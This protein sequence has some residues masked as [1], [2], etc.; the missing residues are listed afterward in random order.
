MSQPPSYWLRSDEYVYPP[1]QGDASCGVA[2]IGGG[3]AGLSTAL[4]LSRRGAKVIL[5]ERDTIG[6]GSTGRCG[7]LLSQSS[8]F[9]L[10][11]L[12]SRFGNKRGLD[13]YRSILKAIREMAATVRD[14]NIECDLEQTN[15]YFVATEKAHIPA[16]EEELETLKDYGY[17][18]RLVTGDELPV[19]GAF[20]ALCKPGDYAL[21]P[22]RFAKGLGSVIAAHA[23]IHEHTGVARIRNLNGKV[24]LVTD[25]GA[26][27]TSD[28]VVIATN[29]K[30]LNAG[31]NALA[32]P[33]VS[34]IAITEPLPAAATEKLGNAGL[35]D[36]N[37]NYYYVR[38]LPDGGMMIGGN[39]TW[40]ST[41]GLESVAGVAAH[42]RS[43]LMRYFPGTDIRIRTAWKGDI[44]L[45]PDALPNV[46]TKG[47]KTL[48][49]VDGMIPGWIAGGMAADRFLTGRSAYDYLYDARR[50][51]GFA[52][53]LLRRM[54]APRSLKILA[55]RVGLGLK[56]FFSHW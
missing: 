22:A 46:E 25:S 39:H 6:H 56:L 29:G 33:F 48:L 49:I 35:W 24:V 47:N 37:F 19:A 23:A 20:A 21:D 55:M 18:G 27:V 54:P 10:S 32:A 16:I 42:L 14:N 34:Y 1:L 30:T 28:H 38:R 36:A 52:A 45:P 50:D 31:M 40:R 12:L 13:I 17:E 26:Q 53:N 2:V 44:A 43:V 7:G 11:E 51:M 3:I 41:L 8:A 9:E 5:L 15:G 4:H